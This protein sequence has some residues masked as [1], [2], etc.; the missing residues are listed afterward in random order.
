[1]KT[2]TLTL[3]VDIEPWFDHEKTDDEWIEYMIEHLITDAHVIGPDDELTQ[4][5]GY[6]LSLPKNDHLDTVIGGGCDW[7]IKPVMGKRGDETLGDEPIEIVIKYVP[8]P[9]EWSNLTAHGQNT[10]KG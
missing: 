1:M 4:V 2:L 9:N 7:P 6:E 10:E 3:T 5:N 8:E